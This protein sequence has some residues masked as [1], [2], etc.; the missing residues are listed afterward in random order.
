MFALGWSPLRVL[1]LVLPPGTKKKKNKIHTQKTN[2]TK[3]SY[4]L[5]LKKRAK[6]AKKASP[7]ATGGEDTEMKDAK[8]PLDDLDEEEEE[9]EEEVE[10]SNNS[11]GTFTWHIKKFSKLRDLYKESEVFTVADSKWYHQYSNISL[12]QCHIPRQLKMQGSPSRY[13]ALFLQLADAKKL[14]PGWGRH[15]AFTIYVV[16]QLVRIYII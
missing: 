6:E 5:G 16:N 2:Q 11:L 12:A 9:E 14:A 10:E 15:V 8:M 3:T 7:V 13:L 4:V 1:L